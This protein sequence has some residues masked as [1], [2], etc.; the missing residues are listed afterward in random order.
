MKTS[1]KSPKI[2]SLLAIAA[3]S[4]VLMACDE[5]EPAKEDTPELITQ[6][7]LTF[8]PVGGGTDIVVKAT[9]PDGIGVKDIEADGPIA[10]KT[11]TTYTLSI[12]LINE[13][14]DPTELEYDITDEVLEEADE[15]MFFFSWTGG[16]ADPIGN[17]NIDN[18]AD[19][20]NYTDNDSNGLPLGLSTTWTTLSALTTDQTFRIVLKHQPDIKSATSTSEDGE[21]DVDLVFDLSVSN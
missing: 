13:L 4:L 11:N 1:V 7:T 21:T 5:D 3:A 19:V 18:R 16:F 2:F 14:L 20:V 8:K 15:H 9:D 6:V 12:E 17:G 10:L